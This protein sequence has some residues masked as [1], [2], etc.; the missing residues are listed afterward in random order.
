MPSATADTTDNVC[1]KVALFR[2]I[3]F[4]MANATAILADLIFVVAKGSVEGG[5][6]TELIPLMIVLSFGRRRCLAGSE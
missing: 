2:A 3:I 1:G 6:F 5:Q 4:T